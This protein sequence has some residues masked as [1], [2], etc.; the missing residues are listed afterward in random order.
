MLGWFSDAIARAS[1]WNRSLNRSRETLMAT[2]RPRRVSRA[3]YTTPMP[4]APSGAWISYGPRRVPVERD[5]ELSLRF[6][7]IRGGDR[8]PISTMG[9]LSDI[10]VCLK[11]RNGRDPRTLL[12]DRS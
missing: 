3:R 10:I 4:P 9:A 5:I 12:A 7:P 2:V 6:Y 11:G 1:R 8:T